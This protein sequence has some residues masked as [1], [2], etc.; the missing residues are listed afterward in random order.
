[1]VETRDR[2]KDKVLVLVYQSLGLVFG[3]LSISPLY[4]YKSTFAGKLRHYQSEDVVFGAFSMIFWTLSLLSLFKY[5]VFVLSANDNG[6]GGIIALYSLLC[7]KTKF[8]LLP[9]LQASDEELSN[10]GC[11]NRNVPPS[12]L[13]RIIEKHKVAKN[14]LLLLVL[15]GA[16]MVISIGIFA[17]AIS[18]LSSI[19]GLKFQTKD[20]HNNT[21][22][23]IA[24]VL[25]VLL[26]FLQHRGFHKVAF[27]FTPIIIL[28]LV[29]ITAVG[30][31]NIFRWNPRVYQ[32]LSPYYVY[33]FFK[34]TGKDGW[35]SLGGIMLC[36]S[37]SEA[38]F[39]DLGHF[40]A[41]SI[42]V[43]FSCIIYPCL[44][45]QYMGQAAFLSK[46]LSAAP[47]SFYASIPD[48]FFWPIFG[49]ATLAGIVASQAVISTTLMII[50]EC[51]AFGCFPR[52]KIVH[53]RRW[54]PGQVYIPEI[55]WIL[56]VLSLLVT[57]GFRNT[58]HI[59][60]AYGIAYMTMTIVTTCLASLVINLA[61]QKSV[62]LSLLFSVL[63]GSVEIIYF[64]SS[65][66]RIPK[67]GWVPLLFSA[68]F[69]FIMY[70]WYYG[71]WK[72]YSQDLHNKLSMRWI[73]TLGPS[74]GIIKVPGIGLIY[75]EL[76][77]GVPATFTHFLTTL[78]A[79]YQVVVFVC[80]KTVPVSHV[81]HK[82][83]FLIGRIGPKSYR[84]YR[85]IIR[86]GYKDI[87]KNEEE[88]ESELVMSIAEFI[89][90]EAEGTG[91][92]DG[93]VDGR[94]AVVRT[95]EKF[96]TRL[97][98]STPSSPGVSNS[99]NQTS[100]ILSGYKSP[101]LQKLQ[102][103]YEQEYSP[104]LTFRRGLRF[105]L[106]N[107]KYKDPRVKEEL[108]ELVEA[109]RAGVTYVIGH[110][111][112]K[113]RSNSSFLHQ[114]AINIAYSFLRKNCRSPAVA[115]NIPHICLIEVGMNYCV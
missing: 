23:L 99:I 18:I 113:A 115:L 55:N 10:P 17:P 44:V 89:Q 36:I 78:P 63:F 9:N 85:C 60:N 49:V 108:L 69:L 111:H 21:V 15:L 87:C 96:G 107:T 12:F 64:S 86:N 8:C 28:W 31:Y 100:V 82:E 39:T 83:R 56:M 32:A 88:F 11:S 58:N 29:S 70:V 54:L 94:M 45:L 43:A 76:A 24:C 35:I 102:A 34:V 61:W 68:I 42:R 62:V 50:K 114:F 91:A 41:T 84:L 16:C 67:G 77:T 1:M 22:V 37:G 105:E 101:T 6:E 51:D 80:I 59:G 73:L 27:L 75:T 104:Q 112:I 106:L 25:L 30:I 52:I 65:C 2:R 72:K 92:V 57:L 20:V 26:F 95:S 93:S 3:D 46:N 98:V 47:L 79:F 5:V 81:F 13:R 7:Q 48:P 74:L 40:S 71:S 110:S 19:E 53:T 38:M 14:C 4:V 90:M 66:M 103:S 97:V 109:K 33:N